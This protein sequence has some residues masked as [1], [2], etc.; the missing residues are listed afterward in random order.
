LT[1]PT[2]VLKSIFRYSLLMFETVVVGADESP[3][4]A[5]AVQQAID[6]VKLTG[7]KLHIVSAYAHQQLITGGEF[8]NSISSAD[9]AQ[10]LLDDLASRA[11]LAGVEVTAH[12]KVGSPADVICEVAAEV[13]ADLII[14]GNKGMKGARRVLGSVPNSVAHQASCSVLIAAT[15]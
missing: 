10:S 13:D 8:A 4:A 9:L 5:E 1:V 15:T 14:V 7:G 12:G 3:T 11:R 6:L 2:L